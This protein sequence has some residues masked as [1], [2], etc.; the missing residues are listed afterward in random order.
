VGSRLRLEDNQEKNKLTNQFSA[1]SQKFFEYGL[2]AGRGDSTKVF[3]ELGYFNRTNDSL[4]N[5]II[6]RVNNSQTFAL[7]SKLIQTK[8]SD[9][10]LFANY[11]VLH[12]LDASN[13]NEPSLNSRMVYNNR[14]FKQLIQSTT[15][16]E[17]NSGSIPQ[18][19]F[20][21]LE[22][23][24]G[25]GV[26]TWNDYNSNGIQELEEFEI[27][28]FVDQGKYIRVFLPNRIYVKTHQN[29]FS[30]SIILNPNQWQN[31]T[32]FKKMLSY[33]YNQTSYLI[34]RKIENKDDNFDLNP[35][36][37]SEKNVLGLNSSFRNSLFFNRGK[38][39]HSF[40]YSYIL[41]QTINLLSVGS[42]EA[43]NSSH[44]LQYNH[45]YRKSWLFGLFAKT[46]HTSIS[47]ENFLER[48]YN[49]KGYQLAPKISYLF[50][51][52]S[53]WDLFY[54][55]QNKEN[56]IGKMETLLQNRFG[57]S[58]SYAGQNKL[59]MNGEISF[60][61]NKY[62]GNEFSSVGFQMLEGLQPGQN[63]TWRLLVQKNLTKFLDINLNYQ[64]RKSETS[65]TIHTGS[66]ELRAY[67]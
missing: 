46:I 39:Y 61:Q 2:F 51:K 26:Y 48:N 63:L 62:V 49:L 7:R 57:T 15:V 12:F 1:L 10:S 8:K 52:S 21:Y 37:N 31:A 36:S 42:Q 53:S 30:Q 14:F 5:G 6:Q 44:Q 27:A 50:T 35:F 55:L 60:Y 23:H 11:R 22:V 41:N 33:F 54:E 64:G 19:E 4:Q 40:T 67:F 43:K 59:T 3:V 25:Q 34:D 17:T 58:F 24:V 32:G 18:Q 65:Q 13:K 28:P 29:K 16:F 38:Q 56:Q 9:L 45:F 66:V 20:T 47:S